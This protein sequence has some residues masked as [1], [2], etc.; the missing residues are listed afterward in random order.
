MCGICGFLG[1]FPGIN[2]IFFGIKMLLNRGY[3]SSGI[4][5]IKNN[6]FLLTYFL[7]YILHFVKMSIFP[8]LNLN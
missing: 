4:C 8:N 1:N 5:G 6:K 7:F 2:H 3:D